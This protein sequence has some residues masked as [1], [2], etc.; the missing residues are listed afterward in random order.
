MRDAYKRK[1]YLNI[2][3]FVR[4]YYNFYFNHFGLECIWF[5][6]LRKLIFI[7]LIYT[8][9]YHNEL[10]ELNIYTELDRN[11]GKTLIQSGTQRRVKN[12]A[13]KNI[14]TNKMISECF[15]DTTPKYKIKYLILTR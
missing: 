3:I 14:F 7:F 13:K 4:K 2:L 1:K 6:A 12:L 8:A 9:Y 10:T 11:R 5:D 15:K